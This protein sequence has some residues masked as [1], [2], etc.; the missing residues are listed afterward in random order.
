[1]KKLFLIFFVSLLVLPILVLAQS[2]KK[3]AAYF[4]SETCPRCQNV[5]KYFKETG[6]YERYDIQKLDTHQSEN[7]E[8]LNNLFSAFG[9]DESNRGVPVVFFGRIFL[10]GDVPI[11]RDFA[12]SMEKSEASFFPEAQII[13]K[14]TQAEKDAAN[15]QKKYVSNI[16]LSIIISAAILDI[17]NPCSL[18]V[19]FSLLT[20]LFIARAKRKMFVFGLIFSLVIFLSHIL[21]AIIIYNSWE[22]DLWQKYLLSSIII[23]AFVAALVNLKNIFGWKKSRILENKKIYKLI[24]WWHEVRKEI[25]EKIATPIGFIGLG[26][27]ASLFLWAGS[28]ESY[29]AII[30]SLKEDGNLIKTNGV[31]FFYN[32]A[33]IFP[34]II[35]S[36]IIEKFSQTKKFVLFQ[37]KI[38]KLIKI[39]LGV[40]MLF[41]GVYLILTRIN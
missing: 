31:L 14:L 22:S 2:E 20:L 28:N 36:W 24:V 15:Q 33:F 6:A 17:L 34:L 1:M 39:F 26:V 21:L 13:N 40:I 7:F 10:A 12:E 35:V 30:S 18:V 3:K 37:E 5:E 32:I 25:G 11:I 8:K 23:L 27:L 19:V 38:F 4:Y 16:P 29:R 9:V 41:V